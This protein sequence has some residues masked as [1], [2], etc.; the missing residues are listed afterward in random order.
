MFYTRMMMVCSGAGELPQTTQTLGCCLIVVCKRHLF[1]PDALFWVQWTTNRSVTLNHFTCCIYVVS[2]WDKTFFKILFSI[3]KSWIPKTTYCPPHS[4]LSETEWR[5]LCY[6]RGREGR[7]VER[8]GK[9]AKS[10]EPWGRWVAAVVHLHPQP[11][12]L[13]C[14]HTHG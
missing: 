9:C 4:F 7:I 13:S 14:Q 2:L 1:L 8:Y 6:T 5:H 11:L 12:L 3:V 10:F